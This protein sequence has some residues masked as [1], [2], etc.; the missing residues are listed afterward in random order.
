MLA[1]A[2]TDASGSG[3]TAPSLPRMLILVAGAVCLVLALRLIQ[4]TPHK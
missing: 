1:L 2:V 4:R 3:Y